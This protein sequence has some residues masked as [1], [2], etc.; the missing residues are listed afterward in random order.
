[1]ETSKQI[2]GKAGFAIGQKVPSN[3]V[4]RIAFNAGDAHALPTQPR[5][6]PQQT[7]TPPGHDGMEADK[8]EQVVGD[9]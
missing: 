1:M 6:L 7:F 4:Q 8:Q 5:R 9:E 2:E 3:S